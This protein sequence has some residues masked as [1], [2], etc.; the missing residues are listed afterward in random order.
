MHNS[1]DLEKRTC[2]RSKNRTGQDPMSAQRISIKNTPAPKAP[3]SG[4]CM[5]CKGNGRHQE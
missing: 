2:G 4:N 5:D 1:N 3:C